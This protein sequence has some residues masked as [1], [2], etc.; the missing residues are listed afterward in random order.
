MKTYQPDTKSVEYSYPSSPN[1]DRF[2]FADG[3]W[4]V[5]VISGITGY[6]RAV[7]AFGTQAQAIDNASKMGLEWN[8]HYVALGRPTTVEHAL[9]N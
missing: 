9:A 8:S 5:E 4:T 2:G 3:C 6:P 1:A 7:R